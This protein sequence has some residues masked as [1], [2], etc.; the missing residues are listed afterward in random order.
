MNS[1][2]KTDTEIIGMKFITKYL[3]LADV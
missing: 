2:V 3:Q 1:F